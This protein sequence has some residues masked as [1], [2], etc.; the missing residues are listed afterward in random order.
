MFK[1]DPI[2]INSRIDSNIFFPNINLCHIG[3]S[4][5]VKL[6]INF[7]KIQ[8]F[9]LVF[10]ASKII[11]VLKFMFIFLFRI[12]HR[13]NFLV[14]ILHESAFLRS[15]IN[16]NELLTKKQKKNRIVSLHDYV[17]E[18]GSIK[19]YNFIDFKKH[20]N[21]FEV[22]AFIPHKNEI[23]T[24]FPVVTHLLKNGIKIHIIDDFSDEDIKSKIRTTYEDNPNITLTFLEES[25]FYN[26]TEILKIIDKLSKNSKADFIIR[27]DSDEYLF[28]NI[29]NMCLKEFLLYVSS[30]EFKF[31]DATVV[32]LY[33]D[34]MNYVS[35]TDATH[36]AFSQE[37][38][39]QKVLRSWRN[40]GTLIGLEVHAG[41]FIENES[42][43]YF[44]MNLTL[45]HASLRN[46][47]QAVEKIKKR[48][49]D[50]NFELQ[51]KGWHSHYLNKSA[52]EMMRI[53]KLNYRND[54]DFWKQNEATR[55]YRIG[56]KP[57]KS[58]VDLTIVSFIYGNG[59][60]QFVEKWLEKIQGSTTQP[61]EVLICTDFQRN[62]PGVRE[63]VLP[64]PDHVKY[65]NAFYL[66]LMVNVADS[67]WILVLDIDDELEPN[68]LDGLGNIES[69]VYLA[70]INSDKI[71]IYLPPSLSNVEVATNPYNSY[72]FGSPF[73]RKLALESPFQE[74]PYTDWIFW[75]DIA[76]KNV[77]FELSNKVG[78]RYRDTS[79]S[80]S[81]LYD[82]DDH[83]RMDVIRNY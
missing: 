82:K 48:N 65:P 4:N 70:G 58:I 59:Y 40:D 60:D 46:F 22:E 10:D 43:S 26:W 15:L 24:L 49:I 62:I 44:P 80:M 81:N 57:E 3:F 71:G 56:I 29:E 5:L 14:L 31:I 8:S 17:T 27:C 47:N 64:I 23:D 16:V 61:K 38:S 20:L 11:D 79:F 13:K 30:T 6:M 50:G 21:E 63:L 39:Y 37:T 76:K 54:R 66:N 36:L 9:I 67:E 19:F 52:I 53:P 2:Y 45:F 77:K 74:H 83:F 55:K 25:E 75:R 28:S 7:R 34:K 33:S 1:S 72:C 18:L 42:E 68:F 35:A 78:Y 73:K 51:T 32:N 41:H 12:V 69:D